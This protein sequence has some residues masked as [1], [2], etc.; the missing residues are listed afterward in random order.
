MVPLDLIQRSALSIRIAELNAQI[1]ALHIRNLG[2]RASEFALGSQLKKLREKSQRILMN[3]NLR[4][5]IAPNPPSP[6]TKT[7]DHCVS[8]QILLDSYR[9]TMHMTNSPQ[10][11]YWFTIYLSTLMSSSICHVLG[12]R[13]NF[14]TLRFT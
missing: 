1:S 8:K 14:V 5:L 2:L 9:N 4:R 3:E 6:S 10:F 7:P 13:V 11:R 12:Y